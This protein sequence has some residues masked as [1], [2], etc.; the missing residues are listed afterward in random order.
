MV[1]LCFCKIP[2]QP[3]GLRLRG[4]VDVHLSVWPSL[5]GRPFVPLPTVELLLLPHC[6]SVPAHSYCCCLAFTGSLWFM[7]SDFNVLTSLSLLLSSALRRGA[8]PPPG[9][10]PGPDGE[11]EGE[12]GRLRLQAPLRGLPPEVITSLLITT[13]KRWHQNTQSGVFYLLV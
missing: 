10:V 13:I 5:W 11:P 9:Q 8:D 2:T 3:V 7:L 12:E 6:V 4:A 1:I